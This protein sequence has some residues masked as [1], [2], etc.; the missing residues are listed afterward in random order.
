MEEIAKALLPIADRIKCSSASA[1]EYPSP[2][3]L[4]WMYRSLIIFDNLNHDNSSSFYNGC[5]QTIG[6][7]IQHMSLRWT[8]GSMEFP[9]FW[10]YRLTASRTL[11]KFIA[12]Q[13]TSQHAMGHFFHGRRLWMSKIDL[14]SWI[15][16]G[17]EKWYKLVILSLGTN[18]L[19]NTVD[20]QIMPI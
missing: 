10:N 13:S 2:I 4:N 9:S 6:E 20:I 18:P 19:L 8:V 3:V 1:N 12:N 7:T 14:A 11:Y 5:T 16:I 15:V 17:G